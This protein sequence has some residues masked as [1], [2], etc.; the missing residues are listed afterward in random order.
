MARMRKIDAEH[1]RFECP[2]C[3]DWHI[4]STAWQVS[5]DMDKP[6]VQPSILV[7]NGHFAPHRAEGSGCWCTF[8]KEHPPEPGEKV[9]KCALCHSFI[10]NGM[11]QFLDDC[12]HE[13]KGQTVELPEMHDLDR[14]IVDGA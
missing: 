9:F 13:L 4:I 1:Y 3:K 14:A 5:E 2:G 10:R 8:Y 6:T 12:S 11:I 7:R